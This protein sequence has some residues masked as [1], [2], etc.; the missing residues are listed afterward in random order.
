MSGSTRRARAVCATVTAACL[1]LSA[2]GGGA[3][4]D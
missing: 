2:C 1:V 3:G 4:A